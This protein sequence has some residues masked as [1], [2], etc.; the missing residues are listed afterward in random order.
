MV[1]E[2]VQGSKCGC[3]GSPAMLGEVS[4]EEQHMRIKNAQLKDEINHIYAIQCKDE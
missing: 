3:Y 4:L 1:W 2:A